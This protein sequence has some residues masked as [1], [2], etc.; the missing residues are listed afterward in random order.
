VRKTL[1]DF[2]NS[3]PFANSTLLKF[4]LG[5]SFLNVYLSFKYEKKAA[6]FRN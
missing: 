4:D 3:S 5:F 2:Q 1:G 6:I